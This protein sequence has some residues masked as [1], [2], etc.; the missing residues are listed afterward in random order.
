MDTVLLATDGS[1]YARHAA[2]HAIAL[3][4]E[5]DATLHVLCVVDRRSLKEPALSS[6]ELMTVLVE[7][8]CRD[9][10]EAVVS[11]ARDEGVPVEWSSR[12]GV[13]HEV[14]ESYAADVG[15]GVIVVG[16]H[17]QRGEHCG[18]VR[19]RLLEHTAREVVLP[20]SEA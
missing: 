8:H 10:I 5:R 19:R 20:P 18:G 1:E 6:E 14:I 2:E 9:E 13:P 12:H 11:M 7:D 17:G 4:K 3:A 16:H 15:A